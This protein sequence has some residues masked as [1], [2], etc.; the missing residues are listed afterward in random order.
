MDT[1]RGMALLIDMAEL[2]PDFFKASAENICN[3]FMQII[4]NKDLEDNILFSL[5][6][7]HKLFHL[8]I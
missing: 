6:S 5:H 2:E 3:T 8:F 1:R 4:P 7:T